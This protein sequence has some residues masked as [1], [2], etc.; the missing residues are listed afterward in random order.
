L[1]D[2]THATIVFTSA[3]F[4]PKII[5]HI[6]Q[7]LE[8]FFNAAIFGLGAF[9]CWR[10]QMRLRFAMTGSGSRKLDSRP[11]PPKN[12]ELAKLTPAVFSVAE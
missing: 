5:V 8:W 3:I 7:L 11:L 12:G 4:V 1:N 6:D 2:V 9:Y 10:S